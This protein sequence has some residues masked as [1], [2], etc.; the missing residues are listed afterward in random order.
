VFLNNSSSSNT[1]PFTPRIKTTAVAQ[2]T[3]AATKVQRVIGDA[4]GWG[5]QKLEKVPPVLN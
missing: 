1:L 2:S 3:A 4:F 5:V